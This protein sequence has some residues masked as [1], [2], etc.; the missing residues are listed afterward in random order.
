MNRDAPNLHCNSALRRVG[1]SGVQ[2]QAPS[3]LRDGLHEAPHS[4]LS[5]LAAA[6]GVEDESIIGGPKRKADVAHASDPTSAVTK[7]PCLAGSS[8]PSAQ[9]STISMLAE[10]V[11]R[12]GAGDGQGGTQLLCLTQTPNEFAERSGLLGGAISGPQG[13]I[14]GVR[15]RKRRHV[16][17]AGVCNFMLTR[18]WERS[19]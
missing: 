4:V 19:P 3:G 2:L 1:G 13:S 7:R 17:A 9:G 15:Q 11:P 10:L 12:L 18:L 8:S 5:R 16:K 14:G 6:H